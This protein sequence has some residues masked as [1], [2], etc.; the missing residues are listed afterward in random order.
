M[1]RPALRPFLLNPATPVTP[2]NEMPIS[3]LQRQRSYQVLNPHSGD[4]ATMQQR[5]GLAYVDRNA[6][7]TRN[8]NLTLSSSLKASQSCP[9][10]LGQEKVC[11]CKYAAEIHLPMDHIVQVTSFMTPGVDE[12]SFHAAFDEI[13]ALPFSSDYSSDVRLLF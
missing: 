10:R 5:P 11:L 9:A 13:Y 1:K 7:T 6:V 8:R 4:T 2:H 3:R 12:V